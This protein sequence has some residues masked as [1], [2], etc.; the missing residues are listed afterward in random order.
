MMRRT[1]KA[2]CR[3]F[4]DWP[5]WNDATKGRKLAGGEYVGDYW[6]QQRTCLRCGATAVREVAS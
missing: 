5:K 6:F 2:T 4:H 1:P 3:L